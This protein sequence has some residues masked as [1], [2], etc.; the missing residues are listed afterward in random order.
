MG[1]VREWFTQGDATDR[2]FLIAVGAKGVNG[3]TE[4]MGGLVLL[5][6]TRDQLTGWLASRAS[7]ELAEDPNDF[8]ATRLLHWTSTTTLTSASLRFAGL[9]LLAH[10][11]VKLVLVVAVLRQKM[12]AYPWRLAFLILFVCYQLYLL[13][14]DPSWGLAALTVFDVLLAWLTYREWRRHQAAH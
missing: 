10:G 7:G 14:G 1:S 8:I 13:R 12:W 2:A 4:V 3:L 9:Y 11:V 6:V 5:L